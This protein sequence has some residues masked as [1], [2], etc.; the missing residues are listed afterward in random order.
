MP[1]QLSEFLRAQIEHRGISERELSRRAGL[2]TTTIHFI[3]NRPE[4]TP[5]YDT[6]VRLAAALEL[7]PKTL[8][9][10]AGYEKAAIDEQLDETVLTLA[11]FLNGLPPELR[12]YALEAC[13]AIA[14]ILIR[15]S[16]AEDNG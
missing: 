14:R 16:G 7:S 6:C 9:Q 8:L 5:T 2:G 12:G 4:S 10:L 11:V 13:W 15:A 1:Q 3:I